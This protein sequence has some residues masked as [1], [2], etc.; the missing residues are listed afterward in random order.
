MVEL[1]SATAV[2]RL[3]GR[4]LRQPDAAHRQ[5]EAL[6]QLPGGA[7]LAVEYKGVNRWNAAEDDR[8]IGSLRANLS[9]GRCRFVMV[10]DKRQD[11]IEEALK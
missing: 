5:A 9:E 11:W 1:K 10:K 8:L 2:E 4:V 6:S 3:L 7:T